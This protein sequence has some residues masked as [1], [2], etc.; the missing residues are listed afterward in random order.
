ME[1][2]KIKQGKCGGELI[3]MGMALLLALSLALCTPLSAASPPAA[4]SAE[5]A[6]FFTLARGDTAIAEI[7]KPTLFLATDAKTVARFAAWIKYNASAAKVAEVDFATYL[8]VAV[9]ADVRPSS[10]YGITI[11]RV[12]RSDRGMTVTVALSGPPPGRAVATV[13]SFPYHVIAV[14][15]KDVTKKPNTVWR[16]ITTTGE[17]MITTTAP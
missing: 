9:F 10:G 8:V 14:P 2:L 16:V 13:I 11:E 1:K 17:E 5:P 12:E 4:D 7:K 6:L 3:G 15:Y